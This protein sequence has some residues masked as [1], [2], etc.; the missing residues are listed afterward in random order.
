MNKKKLV[1]IEL[2]LSHMDAIPR[3]KD[4]GPNVKAAKATG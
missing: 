2:V 1:R 4:H 3:K